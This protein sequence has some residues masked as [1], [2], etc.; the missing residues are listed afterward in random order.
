MVQSVI[1]GQ[2]IYNPLVFTTA[3]PNQLDPVLNPV[4]PLRTGANN[5]A[6]AHEAEDTVRGAREDQVLINNLDN[7]VGGLQP[8]E[9]KV[10][11]ERTPL[12]T[13][14]LHQ[15]TG[16]KAIIQHLDIIA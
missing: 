16:Q 11:G 15:Q 1:M 13:T 9:T 5:A 4:R 2:R 14:D 6:D 3:L 8:E 7:A 12:Q 10:D